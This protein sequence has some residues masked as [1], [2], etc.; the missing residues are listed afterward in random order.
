LKAKSPQLCYGCHQDVRAEFARQFHHRVNEGLLTCNDCHNAHG[1]FRPA[2]LRTNASGDEVC[3]KCHAEKQGPFVYQHEAKLEGCVSC[4]TPHGSTN[5]RLLQQ[6][7]VSLLCLGCH[8][9]PTG[10]G[11]SATPSFH[12][13]SQKYQP[14]TMC[15]AAIH[16]SNSSN[17]FFT[18]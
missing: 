5:A 4:H 15:H 17:V 3:Y 2:Q 16:G 11:A 9:L 6:N 14:C 13:L 7:Q 1:T 10:M 18:P 12:D 8:S